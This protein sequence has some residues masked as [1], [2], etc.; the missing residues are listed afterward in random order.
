MYTID[1]IEHVK[2]LAFSIVLRGIITARN[3]YHTTHCLHTTMWPC[4]FKY[5]L[6]NWYG[7]VDID[8]HAVM[9]TSIYIYTYVVRICI[10]CFVWICWSYLHKLHENFWCMFWWALPKRTLTCIMM[11]WSSPVIWCDLIPL[12]DWRFVECCEYI[13]IQWQMIASVKYVRFPKR[14]C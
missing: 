1:I 12:G 14:G 2:L 7:R 10:Y 13:L 5:D 4:I 3:P 6:D 9:H 11:I 8:L